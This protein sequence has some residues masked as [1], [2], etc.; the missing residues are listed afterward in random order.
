MAL[1]TA[2]QIW[3]S[4]PREKRLT[5]AL[6]LW[7]DERLARPARTA[8]LL[9]WLTARG[10]RL[11]FLEQMPRPR[12]A[13]VM[14]D[15][16]MPEET[17]AQVLLSHHLQHQRKLLARFLD[18][19]GVPHDNGLIKEALAAAPAEDVVRRAVKKMGAEFPAED[20]ELYL[21][22]L[23]ATDPDNWGVLAPFAGDPA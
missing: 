15:G 1:W 8:A 13:Q 20:V 2:R 10:M 5:A 3:H 18:E 22:T 21:R 6:A 16:G 19:L 14:A 9:P 17:A 12:R 11:A 23:I 4:L 7:E